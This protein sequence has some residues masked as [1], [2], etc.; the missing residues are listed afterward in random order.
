MIEIDETGEAVAA[1]APVIE[2]RREEIEHGRRLP[3]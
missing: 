3:P 2:A 1:L